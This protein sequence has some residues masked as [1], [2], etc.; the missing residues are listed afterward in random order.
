MEKTFPL[1]KK[2]LWRK[3]V[4]ISGNGEFAEEYLSIKRKNCLRWQEYLEI[5]LSN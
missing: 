5:K 2:I 3:S 1:A 4:P